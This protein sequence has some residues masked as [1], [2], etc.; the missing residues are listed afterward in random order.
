MI[1]GI[2]KLDSHS[3]RFR[4]K[5]PNVTFLSY[6]AMSFA[7]IHS[8]E[9]AAQLLAAGQ[10]NAINNRP[11]GTGPFKFKSYKK[12]DVVRMLPHEG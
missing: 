3:V 12:D 11:V 5:S 6:F 2:D 1:E 4:L 10:A 8:A 9:Y 7:G